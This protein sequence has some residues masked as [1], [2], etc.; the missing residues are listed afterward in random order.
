MFPVHYFSF[1]GVAYFFLLQ[2]FAL[3]GAKFCPFRPSSVLSGLKSQ[4]DAAIINPPVPVDKHLAAPPWSR[5][6]VC[7]LTVE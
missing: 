2:V 1:F 3:E 7:A 5:C 4:K 6:A